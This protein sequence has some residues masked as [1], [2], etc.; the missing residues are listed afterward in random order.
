M[1]LLFFMENICDNDD[2]AV[3]LMV[4][5]LIWMEICS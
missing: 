3:V 5:I 4:R 1:A 2:G